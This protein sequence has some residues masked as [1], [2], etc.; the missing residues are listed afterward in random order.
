MS[1]KNEAQFTVTP[2]GAKRS[3]KVPHY[4]GIPFCF[5]KRAG[6]AFS[7]GKDKYN[8]TVFDSN[9]KN[10]QEQFFAEAFDHVIDHLYAWYTLINDPALGEMM[11]I[12]EEDH[13]G[14]AAAGLAFL[15]YGE[16]M[17]WF[18]KAA[19]TSAP[20]IE[21]VPLGDAGVTTLLP[22][23]LNV[24]EAEYDEDD[25]FADPELKKTFSSWLK[26]SL[27]PDILKKD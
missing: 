10:G 18:T 2:G 8:E 19:D 9:W 24:E 20:E 7:E 11:E 21:E 26:G 23:A 27:V 4:R 14:H 25:E 3:N 6:E 13:L 1:E 16:E 17:G 5:I 12:E 15:T 22:V